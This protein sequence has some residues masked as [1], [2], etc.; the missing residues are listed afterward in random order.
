MNS[1][2]VDHAVEYF[3]GPYSCSQAIMLTYATQLG[4]DVELALQ[5]GTGFAGGMGR[6]AEVCGA[7]TGA[8]MVIGLKHGM[9]NKDDEDARAKTFELVS[10]L[11]N[12]FSIIFPIPLI[13]LKSSFISFIWLVNC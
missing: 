8:I 9:K 12:R 10:A 5:L 3:K 7:V 1:S 4:L 11:F 2:K 6:H 13:S